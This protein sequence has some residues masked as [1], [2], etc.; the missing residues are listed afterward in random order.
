MLYILCSAFPPLFAQID[1]DAGTTTAPFLR[2][3]IGARAEGMGGAFVALSDDVNAVYWNPAGLSQLEKREINLTYIQWFEGIKNHFVGFAYPLRKIHGAFG[4]NIVYLTVSG[5]D[6]MDNDGNREGALSNYNGSFTVSYAQEVS[7][8]LSLGG[9]LKIAG[10]KYDK[11]SGNA[12]AL[13][14]GLLWLPMD[15]VSFGACFQNLGTKM[16]VGGGKAGLPFTLKGGVTVWLMERNLRISMELDKPIASEIK[17][18]LGAEFW[19]K[20]KVAFRAGYKML[21][22]RQKDYVFSG[23]IGFIAS[24]TPPKEEAW[25]G[26]GP[27]PKVAEVSQSKLTIDYALAS[28]GL[29]GLIHYVSFGIK[30]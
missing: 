22:P 26:T 3:G 1:E 6:K 29:F 18:K 28:H 19:M 24:Y 14:G 2:M 27:S 9:N 21:S 13:D 20:E 11:Y 30:F 12:V 5:L 4:V 7:P 10:Q 16:D 25:L 15:K 8:T 23:G 17:T